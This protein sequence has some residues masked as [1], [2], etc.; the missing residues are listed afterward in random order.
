MI[1]PFY[2]HGDQGRNRSS[3]FS[4]TVVQGTAGTGARYQT[5]IGMGLLSRWRD[6]TH[7]GTHSR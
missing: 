7:W 4:Q 3:I 6:G 1:A 5:V 2:L